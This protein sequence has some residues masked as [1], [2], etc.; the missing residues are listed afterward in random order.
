MSQMKSLSEL[1]PSLHAL[2]RADKLLAVQLLVSALAAEEGIVDVPA[3]ASS[4]ASRADSGPPA[5]RDAQPEQPAA[6]RPRAVP[7]PQTGR[8]G[9]PRPEAARP[10]VA[11]AGQ[12]ARTA[13]AQARASALREQKVAAAAR[14][15]TP[16]GL[17]KVE[18]YTA[19]RCRGEPGP[20]GY[21]TVL[22]HARRRLELQG[23]LAR[24]TGRRLELRGVLAGLELLRT[25]CSVLV[26][27]SSRYLVESMEQRWAH[28]WQ[29]DGWASGPEHRPVPDQD[30]WRRL[31]E[32]CGEHE[33]R[34]VWSK[35]QADASEGEL[36]EE[37]AL[38]AAQES[39]L[40]L[41][42]TY[43]A[44][45][46]AEDFLACHEAGPQAPEAEAGAASASG[47]ERLDGA[48]TEREASE[49][50]A[51]AGAATASGTERLGGALTE[52]ETSEPEAG[53]A[54][55]SGT[56]R[57]GS[58]PTDRE[59]GPQAP[60]PEA[61][62]ATASG[63][64]RPGSAPT[65]REA[66]ETEDLAS[67]RQRACS[68]LEA[69]QLRR[70]EELISRALVLEPGDP[71]TLAVM[72][73]FL[74]RL[75]Q[76]QQALD[77]TERHRRGTSHALLVSRAAAL[78]DLGRWAEAKSELAEARAMGHEDSHELLDV[79][80]RISKARPGLCDE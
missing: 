57:P 6:A 54:T 8:P 70:V 13:A 20:G 21:G 69:Q 23:G 15:E 26:Y 72:C 71:D 64:E 27:T 41:D 58:A 9:K 63:T 42:E 52:R 36:A 33:V 80:S 56:E 78:C 38:D 44:P 29:D 40:P 49:T 60:E 34:F 66:S 50:E 48:P 39:D 11:A 4:A 43:V 32:L 61:G 46:D 22:L 65:E 45:L 75:G 10:V 62:A 31:L 18:I 25:R 17:K 7:M 77:E 55:A 2:S 24:T 73:E 35:S 30:L 51:E 53:A 67:L 5:A 3:E 14:H 37:L 12:P 74:R 19:G 1:T 76:P 16:A 59:A 28:R 68:A 79:A 47:T